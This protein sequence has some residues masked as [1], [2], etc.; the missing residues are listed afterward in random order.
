MNKQQY[1]QT[2]PNDRETMSIL[3]TMQLELHDGIDWLTARAHPQQ[4]HDVAVCEALHHP[5][6]TEEVQL[7]TQQRKHPNSH[8]HL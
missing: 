3:L 1:R 5:D 2:V 4:R 8:I 7:F 6:L